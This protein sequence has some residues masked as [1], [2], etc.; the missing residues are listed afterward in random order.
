MNILF[1]T[2]FLDG[3]EW[4]ER[5][6]WQVM[7]LVGLIL[8]IKLLLGRW[9][10]ATAHYF[11][12]LPVLLHLVSPLLLTG[13]RSLYSVIE[14]VPGV[15]NFT[16]L[17]YAES[18]GAEFLLMALVFVWLCGMGFFGFR[19]LSGQWKFQRLLRQCSEID[20]LSSLKLLEDCKEAMSIGRKV[21]L[22]ESA[23]LSVPAVAGLFRPTILIPKGMIVQRSAAELKFIFL[24]ELAHAKNGDIWV[25]WITRLVNVLHWFNPV[26]RFATACLIR[27]CERACDARVLEC[28][29]DQEERSGYGVMLLNLSNSLPRNQVQPP[30]ALFVLSK[31]GGIKQRIHSIAHFKP[32]WFNKKLWAMLV[33]LPVLLVAAYKPAGYCVSGCL[34]ELAIRMELR[35]ERET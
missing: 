13:P 5:T 25:L 9:L 31:N 22:V 30:A 3:V 17:Y 1:S 14:Y 4:L 21:R 2:F 35:Q 11:L 33:M 6:T 18:R 20:D 15:M 26:V 29:D 28:L 16:I 24:H 23:Q 7:M 32:S 19:F 10:S 12:W 8:I 27:N 34:D